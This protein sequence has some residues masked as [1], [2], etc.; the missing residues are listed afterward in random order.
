MADRR[1]RELVANVGLVATT[2]TTHLTLDAVH[3]L[4]LVARRS[5]A[6]LRQRVARGLGRAPWPEA[7]ALGELLADRPDAARTALQRGAA[8]PSH[9]GRPGRL[10]RRVRAAVA[11]QLGALPAGEVEFPVVAARRA[12][13]EGEDEYAVQLLSRAPS[14][15]AA[16]LLT[17]YRG[18]LA[19]RE[20]GFR[21]PDA[22]RPYRP[23]A[24]TSSVHLLVNSVPHTQSGYSLRSHGLLR[25]LR[26]EGSDA[27]AVTRLGYP[28]TIGVVTA[29]HCDEVDGVPY[30]RLVRAR[31]A[32][33][34]AQR[35]GQTAHL[36]AE[37]AGQ[38][39]PA[40]LHTT[41]PFQNGLIASAVARGTQ[42]PWVYEV[43]GRPELTWVA[44]PDLTHVD[45]APLARRVAAIAAKE[46]EVARLAD[47]VVTTSETMR[48]DLI[49]R[50][51]A[52]AR[53][54]VVPNAVDARLLT[55]GP[56]RAQA[57][58]AVGIP[59]ED[60]WVGSITSV[61]DYEGLDTLVRAVGLARGR[62]VSVRCAIVGD[63]VARPQLL[64]LVS[65]LRL[66]DAVILPGRVPPDVAQAWHRALDIFAVPR[67]DLPVCRLVTPLKPVEA[68]AAGRALVVSDVPALAELVQTGAG[69]RVPADDPTALSLAIEALVADPAQ[70]HTCGE[71]GRE[72]ASRRTWETGARTILDVY[73]DLAREG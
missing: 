71:A 38:L 72:L 19:L 62:G 28:V 11:G 5:P 25:A 57:R 9:R 42:R 39:R 56:T 24:A 37:I 4:V 73:Q 55:Q 30:H 50:G 16:S 20:R 26:A 17:A 32:P 49:A 23:A 48:A 66:R 27:H 68:M 61:V 31:P 58:A 44:R 59:D 69:L 36:L 29:A 34:H 8:D 63:G 21:L 13:T 33:E 41:S 14:R 45:P 10:R 1:V 67:R 6:P 70:R 60:V 15:A 54:V 65:D 64:Q 43:R 52:A 18:E 35:L 51:V 12:W 2:T 46:I 3:F 53:L 40:V 7:A 47:R 22:G